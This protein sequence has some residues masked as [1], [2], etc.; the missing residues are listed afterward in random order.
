MTWITTYTGRRFDY[1]SGDPDI[2][3]DDIAHA[4]SLICRFNGHV[5]EHYSVATHSIVVANLVGHVYDLSPVSYSSSR[6]QLQL[7]A[8]L[9]DATEAYCCDVPTPLKDMPYMKGY[10]TAERVLLTTIYHKYG[11]PFKELP[12]IVAYADHYVLKCEY[13]VLFD[14]DSDWARIDR[15]PDLDKVV[16]LS[17]VSYMG[18]N[19]ETAFKNMFKELTK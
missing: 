15:T 13:D 3:I 6:E 11:L 18:K 7:A 9:H 14:V 12:H 16:F 4:L 10:R 2:H 1:A 8:L 5:R 19:N 17:L